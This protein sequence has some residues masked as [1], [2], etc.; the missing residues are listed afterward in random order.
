MQAW[1]GDASIG[2]EQHKREVIGGERGMSMTTYKENGLIHALHCFAS[3]CKK[4]ARL[5]S[6]LLEDDS[7]SLCMSILSH[8]IG[9]NYMVDF[10]LTMAYAPCS[11]ISKLLCDMGCISTHL[12]GWQTICTAVTQMIGEGSVDSLTSIR[13]HHYH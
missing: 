10:Y 5:E 6:H 4:G 11:F 9:V 3:N 13:S 7:F 12:L 8:F 2:G 1:T